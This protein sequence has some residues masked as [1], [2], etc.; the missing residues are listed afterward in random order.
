MWNHYLAETLLVSL[1]TA[2]VVS[3]AEFVDRNEPIRLQCNAT[4][5][6]T[7]EDIDWFKDGTKLD[8]RATKNPNIIITKY[9]SLEV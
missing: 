4:G 9:V 2:V 6:K 7:P 8:T 3:G 5:P 1:P